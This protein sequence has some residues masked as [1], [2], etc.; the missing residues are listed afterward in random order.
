MTRS[1]NVISG[2]CLLGDRFLT[3][4]I[5]KGLWLLS[6]LVK[7][8]VSHPHRQGLSFVSI[9]IWG[10]SMQIQ[11]NSSAGKTK[12]S[13]LGTVFEAC[14]RCGFDVHARPGRQARFGPI[15][16]AAALPLLVPGPVPLVETRHNA[17]A[18]A[19]PRRSYGHCTEPSCCEKQHES[20]PANDITSG[21]DIQQRTTFGNG[22]S[23]E[24]LK[25]VLPM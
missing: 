5:T 23:A 21:T 14:H 12:T 18:Q 25:T 1:R 11:C 6:L 15:C 9:E 19:G 22:T 3:W 24:V 7:V 16:F 17:V 2:L 8:S 20:R 10:C 4:F 13:S